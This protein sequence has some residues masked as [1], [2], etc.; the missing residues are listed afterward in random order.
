MVYAAAAVNAGVAISKFVAAYFT[1]SSAMIAEGIHSTVDMGDSLLLLLGIQRSRKPPDKM[2]PFGHGK[3]LYFWALIVAIIIFGVGGGMSI[4]EGILHLLHPEPIKSL[5]WNYW[6]LGIAAVLDGTSWCIAIREFLR[7][8]Q[9]G[10]GVWETIHASKDPTV[11]TV[12]FEDSADL[13]GLLLAFLGVTLGHHLK[14]P[15][16]DGAASILIGLLLA[17]LASVL[18]HESKGLLVGESTDPRV[19]ES[20]RRIA[21]A[22]PAVC[23]ADQPPTM[24]LVPHQVL[25]NLG[26]HFCSG[27]SVQELEAAIHRL[28]QTIRQNHPDVKRIF[29]E[30]HSLGSRE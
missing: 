26:I 3:E 27:L 11:F 24:Q 29:I 21:D 23:Y 2:H 13:L 10:A 8:K 6:V 12:V 16:Y 30:A 22:D 20:I 7:L 17:A 19:V 28:E 4:Y 15:Y 14:N 5:T 18:A 9:P 1:G 25:L